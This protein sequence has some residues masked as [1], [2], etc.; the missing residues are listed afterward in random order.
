MTAEVC[1]AHCSMHQYYGTQYSI[2]NESSDAMTA[3]YST[4]T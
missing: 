3:E 1:L 4:E 2:E